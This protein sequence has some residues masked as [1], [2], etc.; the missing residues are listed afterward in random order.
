MARFI[1]RLS[2]LVGLAASACAAH[3]TRPLTT[4]SSVACVGGA[5]RSDADAALYAACD[6]V[7]GDLQVSSPELS[8]LNALRRLRQVEGK[9]EIHGNSRLESLTGL[10]RLERVGS[11]SVHD[12]EELADVRALS[13]L[14]EA[15]S[16]VIRDV[17]QLGS[18]RGL[19]GL[20]EVDR[21]VIERTGIYQAAGLGGLTRV[22][23]LTVRDNS[24]LNSLHGLGSLTHARRV[25]IHH[26]PRLCAF[27][28]LPALQR[29]ERDLSVTA[30]RGLTK[31]QV[32]GLLER[33]EH[34]PREQAPA[35]EASLR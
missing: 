27:G 1:L 32:R 3:D 19:E 11:L 16:V 31:V 34:G 7:H 24:R 23:Q 10:E 8:D 35:L 21:L 26:N 33:V 12:N 2:M 30:N 4:A 28:L 14:R 29:V 22:G 13:Q 6:T 20:R 18:L 9:L 17:P 5:I 25:E 15:S